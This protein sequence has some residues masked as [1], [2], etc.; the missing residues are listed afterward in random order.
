MYVIYVFVCLFD[1][2]TDII[3]QI[4]QH[5]ELANNKND[6]I[7][8][9]FVTVQYNFTVYAAMK[10]TYICLNSDGTFC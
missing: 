5:V 2:D 3:Q 6:I 10:S 4:E 8:A 1:Y 7:I 9:S